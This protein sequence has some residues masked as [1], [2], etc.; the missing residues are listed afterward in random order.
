MASWRMLCIPKKRTRFHGIDDEVV[1]AEDAV[2]RDDAGVDDGIESEL[3]VGLV[4]EP[5]FTISE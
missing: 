5:G 3:S 2:L 4:E 1:H